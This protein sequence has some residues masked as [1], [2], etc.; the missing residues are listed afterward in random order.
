MT[1]SPF[2][3]LLVL[4]SCLL[5]AGCGGA[6]NKV[7]QHLQKGK[8]YLAN[9]DYEKARVEFKNVLQ[10]NPDHLEGRF[11]LARTLEKIGELRQSIT[12]YR[13]LLSLQADHPGAL[14]RMAELLFAAKKLEQSEELLAR[15]P[16]GSFDGTPRFETLMAALEFRRGQPAAATQRLTALLAAHADAAHGA[17]LLASIYN[18]TDQA[19]K[20]LELLTR[21]LQQQ[22]ESLQV[23]ASL[24]AM[25]FQAGDLE[26]SIRHY[27]QIVADHPGAS[28][29]RVKLARLYMQQE[30][31]QKAEQLLR[32]GINQQPD[33]IQPKLAL[34]NFLTGTQGYEAAVT[35]LKNMVETAPKDLQLKL[36]LGELHQNANQP[37]TAKALYKEIVEGGGFAPEALTARNQI[38]RIL[39]QQNQPDAAR[40]LLAEVLKLNS[41]DQVALTLR[42]ELALV[43][44]NYDAAIADYR[45]LLKDAPS[46]KALLTRLAT[47]HHLSGNTELAIDAWRNALA[48]H[49][50]DAGLRIDYARFLTGLDKLEAAGEQLDLATRKSPEDRRVLPL[51]VQNLLAQ[52]NWSAAQT[53]ANRLIEQ[54]PENPLGHYLL[55]MAALGQGQSQ[56]A[57]THFEASLALSASTVEPL[58]QAVELHL[59]NNQF[60]EALALIDRA[61]QE[62]PE[63]F[64]AHNLRGT[65]LRLSGRRADAIAAFNRATEL[66]PRWPLPYLGLSA[67]QF[68]AGNKEAAITTMREALVATGQDL[69]IATALAALLEQTGDL[70]GAINTLAEV[71]QN[72]PG[73]LVLV[74]NM[75][76][77]RLSNPGNALDPI[78]MGEIAAQLKASGN[79]AFIDTSAWIYTS[80]GDYEEAITL[81]TPLVE[82]HPDAAEFHYHLG[83]AQ[84]RAG[85][86]AAAKRH[87]QQALTISTRFRG[88][89]DAARA[90]K[91][92]SET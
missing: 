92:L 18:Q 66:A 37:D 38:A 29:H 30:Q 5:L 49:D 91:S 51:L 39:L 14:L 47:A 83:I 3:L 58:T 90:L 1:A 22:P 88:S 71:N 33:A 27:Q 28:T 12:Q 75:A 26:A 54:Q 42:A 13:S 80:L 48:S 44:K 9:S 15:I 73:S 20:A 74:N 31:P 36:A 11:Q 86:P 64:V 40:Q 82:K 67:E 7:G 19:D 61:L 8:D 63:N 2:R 6:E 60:P 85:N 17:L 87:L 69:S 57:L 77:L 56:P 68:A 41:R 78:T 65:V 43:E 23:R 10:I 46:D 35:S 55:G 16:A 50:S 76:M 79:A 21:H 53:S 59:K 70:N 25:L 34:I 81:L 89:K 32:E 52:K 84:N 62:K 24:A 45:T 4:I 72:N